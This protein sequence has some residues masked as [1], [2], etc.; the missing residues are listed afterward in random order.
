MAGW[1]LAGWLDDE[2]AVCP[3]STYGKGLACGQKETQKSN[4]ASADYER[5]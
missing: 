3:V 2:F 4:D 1:L 5:Q